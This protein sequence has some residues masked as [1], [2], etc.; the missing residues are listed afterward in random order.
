MQV[1]DWL[2]F[3]RRVESHINQ[4]GK[5]TEDGCKAQEKVALT[6]GLV[7]AK[8]SG[9]LT[10]SEQHVQRRPDGTACQVEPMKQEGYLQSSLQ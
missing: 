5:C 4:H 9:L 7:C 10:L 2:T 6:A 8:H 3:G 1:K